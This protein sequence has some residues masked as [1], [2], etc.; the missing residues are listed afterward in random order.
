M[1]E[2]NSKKLYNEAVKVTVKDYCLIEFSIFF[3][4]RSVRNFILK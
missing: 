4:G 3:T 1:P 2:T